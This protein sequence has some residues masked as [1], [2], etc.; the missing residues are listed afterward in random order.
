VNPRRCQIKGPDEHGDAPERHD[1]DH[2][3]GVIREAVGPRRQ[4]KED[5]K[6]DR[7]D[8]E[9]HFHPLTS[10]WQRPVNASTDAGMP[11]P[12]DRFCDFGLEARL[13]SR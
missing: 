2:R 5:T 10:A 7:H 8:P 13:S 4:T 3:H 9:D 11:F 1:V 6:Q 12:R